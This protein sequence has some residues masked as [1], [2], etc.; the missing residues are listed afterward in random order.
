MLISRVSKNLKKLEERVNNLLTK[1]KS[2]PKKMLPNIEIEYIELSE[3]IADQS[4]YISTFIT[5]AET[6]KKQWQEHKDKAEKLANNFKN[7]W[8]SLRYQ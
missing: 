2:S 5:K 7:E 4:K 6:S 3:D 8:E 1:A